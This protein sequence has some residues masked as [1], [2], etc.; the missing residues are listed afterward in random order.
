MVRFRASAGKSNKTVSTS[1]S[2]TGDRWFESISLQ[3][4]VNNE[5][6]DWGN[7]RS[8]TRWAARSARGLAWLRY[9]FAAQVVE[10]KADARAAEIGPG[11]GA[12]IGA[13]LF[14]SLVRPAAILV[15]KRGR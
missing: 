12:D 14:W 11:T 8:Q 13:P 6:G 9:G 5:P 4:R 15:P 7:P 3:Q 1:W 2:F 10:L